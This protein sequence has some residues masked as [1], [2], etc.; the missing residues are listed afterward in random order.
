MK[1]LK[2]KLSC[3]TDYCLSQCDKTTTRK[4]SKTF[5]IIT[6]AKTLTRWGASLRKPPFLCDTAS[7][8]LHAWRKRRPDP[9]SHLTSTSTRH[10]VRHSLPGRISGLPFLWLSAS[11]AGLQNRG[12]VNAGGLKGARLQLCFDWLIA[13]S[14]T[15]DREPWSSRP[16]RSHQWDVRPVIADWPSAHNRCPSI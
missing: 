1:Y 8:H 12:R 16:S 13:I 10:F 7:V 3:V 9:N 4:R 6:G 5:S 2:C 11:A 14:K 15:P